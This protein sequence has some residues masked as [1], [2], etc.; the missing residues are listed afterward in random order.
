MNYCFLRMEKIKTN[1]TLKS[2]YNHDYRLADVKNADKDRLGSNRELIRPKN[3]EGVIM[4]YNEAF[5][6]RI[7]ALPYY[8]NHK[9]RSNAVL[10]YDILMAYT[11]EAS[12]DREK[13]CESCV[14][15]LE[16]TFNVA[17]DGKSNILSAVYHG[18]EYSP[19]IHAIVIPVDENGKLNASRF[20]NGS[21]AMTDLQSSYALDMERF[22]LQ[23]GVVRSSAYH[24]LTSQFYA[25]IEEALKAIPKPK[26]RESAK[27]YYDRA[28]PFLEQTVETACLEVDKKS[29]RAMQALDRKHQ[30]SLAVL[31]EEKE[32]LTREKMQ[33]IKEI[34]ALK[35]VRDNLRNSKNLRGDR[36]GE[37][38]R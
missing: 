32:S 6:E 19:H 5:H 33:L 8:E 28:Y 2:R 34:E 31:R 29:R 3:W 4:D 37:L 16:D 1:G 22:G 12:I 15:W 35:K 26:D 11:R 14:Q 13:W 30:A 9:I 38:I 10:A 20:T 21:R 7:R 18:D 27:D 36:D 23:R 25:G 24:R 17:P